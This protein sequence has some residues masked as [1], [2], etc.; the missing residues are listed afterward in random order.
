MKRCSIYIMAVFVCFTVV[1]TLLGG[2]GGEQEQS[3]QTLAF[4]EEPELPAGNDAALKERDE[5]AELKDREKYAR[6]E[7]SHLEQEVGTAAVTIAALIED[8]VSDLP[9]G[10]IYFINEDAGGRLYRMRPDGGGLTEITGDEDTILYKVVD[11]WVYYLHR[12]DP[13]NVWMLRPDGSERAVVIDHFPLY[14]HV[15]D[16]WFY[17]F[18]IGDFQ[19]IF[20]IA[21]DGT[22]HD[23]VVADN[24][25]A[26][27]VEEQWLYYINEDD[28]YRI[29]RVSLENEENERMRVGEYPAAEMILD[30]DRIYYSHR[31]DGKT[32]Y[33]T[34]VPGGCTLLSEDH[35]LYITPAAGWIYYVRNRE[36]GNDSQSGPIYK[37]RPDGSERTLLCSDEAKWIS[38]SGNW[39]FYH[40]SDDGGKIYALRTDGSARA[41]VSDVAASM[42]FLSD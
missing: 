23:M 4:R 38:V 14:F 34:S 24:S 25:A 42:I 39:I 29:Y 26:I 6:P 28:N 8:G 7:D 20:K 21:I 22:D 19:S 41:R 18:S 27:V 17:Y 9:G 2:C 10:W 11:G 35:C 12:E 40:N 32:L 15:A 33:R 13:R 3:E 37:I 31:E 1:P 30:G 16:D 5:N 36:P